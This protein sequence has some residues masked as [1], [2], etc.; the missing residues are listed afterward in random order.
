[1]STKVN[2]LIAA[3]HKIVEAIHALREQLAEYKREC[4]DKLHELTLSHPKDII[5]TMKATKESDPK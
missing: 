3:Q 4:V 1:M 2:D 5:E